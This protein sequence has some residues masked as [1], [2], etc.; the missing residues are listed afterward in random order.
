MFYEILSAYISRDS[1][2]YVIH[3][4]NEKIL[5]IINPADRETAFKCKYSLKESVYV[6]GGEAKE[7]DGKITVPPMSAGYYKV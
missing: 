1:F 2:G 6:F 7:T 5:V 3:N 4:N